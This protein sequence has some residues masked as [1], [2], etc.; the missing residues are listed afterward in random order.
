MLASTGW[1]GTTGAKPKARPKPKPSGGG[2]GGGGWHPSGR[3][4]SPGRLP[5]WNAQK[6][7]GPERGGW[8]APE[9]EW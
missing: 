9:P 8:G 4:S 2:D 5:D 7:Q 3:P 6:A 1:G